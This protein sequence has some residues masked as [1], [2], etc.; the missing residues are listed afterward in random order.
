MIPEDFCHMEHQIL[1]DHEA[2]AV[3]AACLPRRWGW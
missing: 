3:H 2:Q 1:R